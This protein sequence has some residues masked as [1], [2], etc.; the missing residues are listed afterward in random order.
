MKY[1][2][3]FLLITINSY[4]YDAFI[5]PSELEKNLK[6]ET[7]IILDVNSESD[8]DKSHIIGALHV[9]ISKLKPSKYKQK[10]KTLEE[11]LSNRWT[12]KYFAE[13]GISNNSDIV[14]YARSSETDQLHASYLA[15]VLILSGFENVSILDGGY[16]GWIFK[17]NRLVS[18]EEH[19]A[20]EDGTYKIN[21]NPD[22]LVDTKYLENN[23]YNAQIIDSRDTPYYF[24]TKK[25]LKN[26]GFGHIPTAKSSYYKDKFLDDLTLRADIELEDIY[27]LGLSLDREKEIIVYGQTI[28]DASM[29]W[30]I[31]YK[32]LDYK[33][34]KIYRNG[35]KEWDEKGLHTTMF[36]WE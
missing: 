24:G 16:M 15:M 9:D 32:K 35:F 4:A 7:L 30:Y 13:L 6:S 17:Y 26:E 19:E 20:E 36:S 8:Y 5:K 29:N 12:Q 27:I 3:L 28:L 25:L 21:V 11:V 31:L 34:V 23:L 33:K 22:I 10:R 14:I 18:T 2:L 1:I